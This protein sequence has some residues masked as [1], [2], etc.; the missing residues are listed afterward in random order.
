MLEKYTQYNPLELKAFEDGKEIDLMTYR[1]AVPDGV[2][3]KGIELYLTGYGSYNEFNAYILK[4]YAEN[5]YDALAI[6]L[7]GF[8]NSGGTRA[9][10]NSSATIYNDIE[11]FINRVI[12]KYK[13]DPKETPFFLHGLSFGGLCANNIAL[14]NPDIFRGMSLVV[15]FFDTL[16]TFHQKKYFRWVHESISFLCPK[17]RFEMVKIP[18]YHKDKFPHMEKDDKIITFGTVKS[19]CIFNDMH[20]LAAS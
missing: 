6:D 7:R 13:V 18:N 20:D 16:V 11:L 12:C 3:L 14:R 5:G 17:L 4:R 15:P 19:L 9:Y 8:G 2:Q 1:Y 10:L